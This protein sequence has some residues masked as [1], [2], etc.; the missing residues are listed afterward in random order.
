MSEEARF[1]PIRVILGLLGD[2]R[3]F[4]ERYPAPARTPLEKVELARP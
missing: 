1:E 3:G 4:L 2:S